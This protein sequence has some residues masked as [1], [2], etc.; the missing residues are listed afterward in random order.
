MLKIVRR[1]LQS[2]KSLSRDLKVA[3]IFILLTIPLIELSLR[4]LGFNQTFQFVQRYRIIPKNFTKLNRDEHVTKISM[5]FSSLVQYG[6]FSGRCLS[7]SLALWW[8]LHHLEIPSVVRFGHRVVSN[9]L[10]GHAWVEIE[11]TPLNEKSNISLK[12]MPFSKGIIH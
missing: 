10:M 2:F 3:S 1:K 4:S 8:W 9:D 7:Q 5:H 11:G 12:F 6:R